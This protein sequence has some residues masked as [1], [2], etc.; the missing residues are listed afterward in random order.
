MANT[1]EIE[2]LYCGHRFSFTPYTWSGE[3]DPKC[4]HC[5]ESKTLKVLKA[6]KNDFSH[7]AFGYS[8]ERGQR[9]RV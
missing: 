1:L 2:C 9:R 8:Y 6:D 7:D 5:K 4:P 3:T